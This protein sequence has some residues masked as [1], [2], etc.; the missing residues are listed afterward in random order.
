MAVFP[1]YSFECGSK[2]DPEWR[3]YRDLLYPLPNQLRRIHNRRVLDVLEEE[4]DDHGI[5]RIVDHTIYF[6]SAKQRTAF[7]DAAADF[8]FS[9]QHKPEDSKSTERP[10]FLNLVR[11]DIV[12]AEHIN[13]VVEKL[14][15]LAES[16]SGEYDGWGCEVQ[17]P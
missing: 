11:S 13:D 16:F 5:A 12:A 17:K 4:G 2:F 10:F 8:G 1:H 14:V 9:I 6:R 15:E 7:T 3:Q